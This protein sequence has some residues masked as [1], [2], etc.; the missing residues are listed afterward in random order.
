[1]RFLNELFIR[2]LT[3]VR[4]ER[5]QTGIEYALVVGVVAIA[6]IIA[7]AVLAPAVDTVVAD[8]GNCLDSTANNCSAFGL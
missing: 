2:V 5:A 7:L 8:I 6:I 1:M 3:A 4:S